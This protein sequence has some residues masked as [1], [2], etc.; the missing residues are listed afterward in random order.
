MKILFNIIVAVVLALASSG[1]SLRDLTEV[2]PTGWEKQ[3]FERE[4]SKAVRRA[5]N[6]PGID[7]GSTIMVTM[8]GDTLISPTDST[9]TAAQLRTVY[10]DIQSPAYPRGIS[11]RTLEIASII[12]V[13]SVIAGVIVLILLGVFVVI[14]RRRHGRNKAINHAIDQSYEL[15]EAFFTGVPSSPAI[16]INQLKETHVHAETNDD[17]QADTQCNDTTETPDKTASPIDVASIRDAVKSIGGITDPKSF[18]DLRN[19]LMLI[20]FGAIAFMFFLCMH[21]KALAVLC[22]GSLAILGGAKLLTLL[23]SKRIK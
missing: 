2:E 5:V 8:S 22:G 15:P 1:C 9:L 6:T 16:T 3:Q 20:G 23:F 7:N 4:V 13:I 18:K 21:N 10:V 11:T 12:S 17:N 14:I 19:G